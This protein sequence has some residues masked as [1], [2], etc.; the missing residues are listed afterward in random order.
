MPTAD[1]P[2]PA[3]RV[4]TGLR[5]RHWRKVP[6]PIIL[7]T[8]W[9]ASPSGAW[10]QA[11]ERLS[12]AST[13]NQL[14]ASLAQARAQ[15]IHRNSRVVLC[16]SVDGSSCSQGLA[17]PGW[18]VFV[19]DDG[20]GRVG[21]TEPVLASHRLEASTALQPSPVIAASGDRIEF[22][23]NGL[24]RGPGGR[25]LAHARMRLCTDSGTHTASQQHLSLGID[26]RTSLLA[27]ADSAH[28][29]TPPADL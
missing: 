26:G 18:L 10:Q 17:W 27:P 1:R 21:A 19:D 9:W 25:P 22:G 2:P 24:P 28:C 6:L 23:P 12:L 3:P 15:A 29:H 5:P 8:V 16:R 14:A 13:A 7:A 11:A 20:D 4:P